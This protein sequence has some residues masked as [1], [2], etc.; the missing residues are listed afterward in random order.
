MKP[1]T[2]ILLILLTGKL[3]AQDNSNISVRLISYTVPIKYDSLIKGEF[4]DKRY[5][6]SEYDDVLSNWYKNKIG[7]AEYN[8]F[9]ASIFNGAVSGKFTV[10]HPWVSEID[11]AKP[12]FN[13]ITTAEL[14]SM[15]NPPTDTT[16]GV[17]VGMRDGMEYEDRKSV[18]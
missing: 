18:V 12:K 11:G 2:I 17:V 4:S 6:F 9:T 13:V 1:I 8:S 5:G 16:W 10:Y 14:E 15:L 7:A 3:Y